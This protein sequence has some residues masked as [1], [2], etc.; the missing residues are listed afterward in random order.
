MGAGAGQ[1]SLRYI[2]RAT[3]ARRSRIVETMGSD[4]IGRGRTVGLR[5]ERG[6]KQT[7]LREMP[8]ALVDPGRTLV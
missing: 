7:F 5:I 2:S 3:G 4:T 8:T 6:A 1:A